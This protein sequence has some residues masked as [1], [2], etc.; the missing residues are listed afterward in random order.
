MARRIF[1]AAET[2]NGQRRMRVHHTL[3]GKAIW[4]ILVVLL[5]LLAAAAVLLNVAVVVFW[6]AVIVFLLHNSG[7]LIV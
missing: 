5:L 1:Q 6:R 3:V 4:V 7:I 2:I